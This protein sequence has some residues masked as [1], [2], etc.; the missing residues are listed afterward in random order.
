M[1]FYNLTKQP[2]ANVH[3]I[4][5][6]ADGHGIRYVIFVNGCYLKCK[7]C[8]NPDTWNFQNGTM[9]R[10]NEIAEK[11][12]KVKN[13]IKGVT[14]TGGEPLNSPYFVEDLFNRVHDMGLDTCLDTTGYASEYYMDIVIP[15]CDQV[16]FC[17]KHLD[18]IKYEIL[19]GAKPA[20]SLKFWN[21][22]EENKKPYLIRHIVIPGFSDSEKDI[23]FLCDILKEK[24]NCKGI[25]LLPYHKFGVQKCEHLNMN[26]TSSDFRIPTQDEL[27]NIVELINKNGI[28]VIF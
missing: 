28:K 20:K 17:I 14:V 21:K 3:S 5:T 6:I 7:I 2:I 4:K 18:P 16:L 13:Y 22:L 10:A 8:A 19:T 27:D 12:K 11:I 25:E 24:P 23:Q 9:T 15:T 1:N 26:Y